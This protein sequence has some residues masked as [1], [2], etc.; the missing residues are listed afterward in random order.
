MVRPKA[1]RKGDDRIF[2]GILDWVTSPFKKETKIPNILKN[3]FVFLV[4]GVGVMAVIQSFAQY[5]F[6]QADTLASDTGQ[7][8]DVSAMWLLLILPPFEEAIF[9]IVPYHYMGRKAAFVGSVMWALLHVIGRNW[10]IV[11]FQL[12]M[13]M[14]YY[15]LV[16]S[17]RYRES[18]LFHEAFNL[19]PLLSCFFS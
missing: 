13:S 17:G 4:L 11:G 8:C 2:N 12:T 1:S 15:K 5:D 10:A 18:V 7:G 9:R 6:S 16:T 19:L 14:F 3:W